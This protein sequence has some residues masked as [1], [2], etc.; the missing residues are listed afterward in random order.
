MGNLLTACRVNSV[1]EIIAVSSKSYGPG[2]LINGRAFIAKFEPRSASGL[3]LEKF[4]SPQEDIRLHL[5][6][7]CIHYCAT[8]IRRVIRKLVYE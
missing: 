2:G 1:I 5:F 3:G 7:E 8:G 6:E 4:G